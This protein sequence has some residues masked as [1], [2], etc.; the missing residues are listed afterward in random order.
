MAL[1]FAGPN[2]R[3]ARS[4]RQDKGRR[5]YLAGLAAEDGVASDYVHR[6]YPLVARRW[7]GQ[8]GEI[9]L[10][11]QDGDG[12][13]IVEVKHSRSFA[14]AAESLSQRQIGR[15]TQAAEEFLGTMPRGSLTNVRFDLALVDCRGEIRV[16]ENALY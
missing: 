6:G 15:L 12:V 10:I 4:A 8:A 5:G 1:D 16:I 9:D 7:R 3:S 11:M 13:V 14:R 2:A